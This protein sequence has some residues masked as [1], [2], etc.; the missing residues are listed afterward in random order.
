MGPQVAL[1]RVASG[2][3]LGLGGGDLAFVVGR[4]RA[5]RWVVKE[6]YCL[7]LAVG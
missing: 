7:P 5:G 2:G 4:V 6:L 3:L 1:A